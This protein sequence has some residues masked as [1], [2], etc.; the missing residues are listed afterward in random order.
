MQLHRDD[1][2]QF[3]RIATEVLPKLP[4][5]GDS[6]WVTA[7][8]LLA[9]ADTFLNFSKTK[10]DAGVYRFFNKLK[11]TKAHHNRHFVDIFFNTSIQ[12][13]FKVTNLGL[14]DHVDVIKAV[15][16]TLGTVYFIEYRYDSQPE[17]SQSFWCSEDFNFTRVLD[18][19]WAD[20]KGRILLDIKKSG[21]YRPDKT[22]CTP[23]PK[24]EDPLFGAAIQRLA[25]VS[26]KQRVYVKDKVPRTYLFIGDQGTGK[27]T[28]ATLFAESISSRVLCVEAEGLTSV[29]ARDL[30]LILD[31]LK[32]GFI[33]VDDIDRAPDLANS[34]TRLFSILTNFKQKHPQVTIILT[35]ND[36]K[37]LDGALRRP[38]RIDEI[39]RFETPSLEERKTLLQ[40]YLAEFKSECEDLDKLAEASDKLTPAYLRE[41][42]L[43]CRYNTLEQVL[44][45]VKQQKELYVPAAEADAKKKS[46]KKDDEE[47]DEDEDSAAEATPAPAPN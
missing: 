13:K 12:S 7:I 42:A 38:G 29:G 22:E 16:P 24:G 47:E 25:D 44:E 3:F 36:I 31:G 20:Y 23:L 39:L 45:I 14:G 40:G 28:F 11:N 43:Q 26:E 21:D 4:S 17:Y 27:T 1:V 34:L 8:R 35:A 2:F 5:R 18:G 41:F 37:K 19:L 6:P 46:K 30:D 33:I 10:K 9:I 15:S 32:P